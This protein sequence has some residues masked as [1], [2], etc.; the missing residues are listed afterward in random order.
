MAMWYA[1][2]AGYALRQADPRV[3]PENEEE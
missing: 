2:A 3:R 1:S